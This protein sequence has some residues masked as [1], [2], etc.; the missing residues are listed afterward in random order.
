M[1]AFCLDFIVCLGL[2]LRCFHIT[3]ASDLP[4]LNRY[5]VFCL[6]SVPGF[7]LDSFPGFC[8]GSFPGFCLDSFP[9]FCLDAFPGFCRLMTTDRCRSCEMREFLHASLVLAWGTLVPTTGLYVSAAF[10]G[11]RC[12]EVAVDT[13]VSRASLSAHLFSLVS[14]RS[15]KVDRDLKPQHIPTVSPAHL[16]SP[17]VQVERHM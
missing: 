8:L 10:S 6:G 3:V 2:Q 1:T 11:L 7:C 12:V 5:C 4:Y 14:C 13:G 17:T 9:G 15:S 16:P